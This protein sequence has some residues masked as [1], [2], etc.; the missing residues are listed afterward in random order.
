MDSRAS[1]QAWFQL[2]S[3]R[4]LE[5]SLTLEEEETSQGS[6][7]PFQPLSLPLRAWAACVQGMVWG[8]VLDTLHGRWT[9]RLSLGAAWHLWGC[10]YSFP[11][12]KSRTGGHGTL[13]VW[14]TKSALPERDPFST[15]Q[16]WRNTMMNILSTCS[17]QKFRSLTRLKRLEL[18]FKYRQS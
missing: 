16:K 3:V 5:A 10:G 14:L 11:S 1:I 8:M 9:S 12:T 17:F 18:I 15:Y 13:K 7:Q 4:Y 2:R 6:P